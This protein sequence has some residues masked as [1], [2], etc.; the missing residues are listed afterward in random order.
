MSKLARRAGASY[1]QMVRTWPSMVPTRF[2]VNWP[3]CSGSW[4]IKSQL[5]VSSWIS[6]MDG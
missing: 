1:R 2:R 3:T 6:V 4:S 5:F